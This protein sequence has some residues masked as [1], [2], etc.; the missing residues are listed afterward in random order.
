MLTLAPELAALLKPLIISGD[1][2][3]IL[4]ILKRHE[5][6]INPV[7][8][9]FVGAMSALQIGNGPDPA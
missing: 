5:N 4:A 3:A 8:I 9:Y 2:L 7:N 1:L 6:K